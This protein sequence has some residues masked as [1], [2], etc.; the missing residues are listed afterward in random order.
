LGVVNAGVGAGVLF[1]GEIITIV[2]TLGLTIRTLDGATLGGVVADDTLGGVVADD[3]LGGVVA[4]DT[5]GGVVADDTLGGVVG[6]ALNGSGMGVGGYVGGTVVG[7]RLGP[8]RSKV[9]VVCAPSLFF[10][11]TPTVPT[12]VVTGFAL[13]H[14]E[15]V[16]LARFT[17][18]PANH[19]RK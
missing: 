14:K 4:D 8:S 13:W 16:Y 6:G 1:G 15:S 2:G 18:D 11:H 10:A 5:L 9:H 3:T 17:V 12:T 19:S 7:G